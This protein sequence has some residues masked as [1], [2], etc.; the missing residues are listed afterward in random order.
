MK[1]GS[2]YSQEELDKHSNQLNDN[3][4]A[5]WQSRGYE[6]KPDSN[7]SNESKDDKS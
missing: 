1:H 6:E 2:F 7:E 4:D 5:F 3:N